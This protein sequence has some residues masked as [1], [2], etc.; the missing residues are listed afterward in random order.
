[1]FGLGLWAVITLP[2]HA[3]DPLL[4]V[5]D[6]K[7]TPQATQMLNILHE[8][9]DYGLHASDYTA[10]LESL[11]TQLTSTSADAA[12]RFDRALTNASARFV[13]DVHSG[14][15]S[16]RTAGFN[17]PA[18]K[19]LA[20]AKDIASRLAG[21]ANVGQSIETYEPR[22]LPYRL[23]KQALAR[24]RELAK[25]PAAPLPAPKGKSLNA[26]EAYEGTAALRSFLLA[27]GDLPAAAAQVPHDESTFDA[28]L[29]ESLR[30]FQSRH[31][32]QADGVLGRQTLAALNVPLSDRVRQIEL[33]M[34]RWR[35]LTALERPDIVVNIPQFRLYALPRPGRSEPLVEMP[36][37]VGRSHNRTPV[38]VGAIEE[39]IFHPYWDVPRSIAR[40]ELLPKARQDATYLERHHFEIV[41]GGSDNA[42][43]VKPSE[44]A[45]DAVETGALRLR[46]RPGPDNALGPVKFVLPN[47]Y[48]V[49]LHGTAEPQLF[50]ETVR[51]FSHGCIRVGDPAALAEYVL[52]DAAGN[53]D[54]AAV[55][56]ALCSNETQRVKL[57]RPVRVI[58][59]YATAAA[60]SSGGILF[61]KDIYGHDA[62]L[63]KLLRRNTSSSLVRSGVPDHAR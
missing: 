30:N 56:K 58:I 4:W 47:P 12:E 26:G 31:G 18:P 21:A 20:E 40:K 44:A 17:L 7:P 23:L 29:A 10:G 46:Q 43:V 55:D 57:T 62:R 51:A 39:V 15:V 27:V 38:F 32:L 34:E 16:A 24:Y 11:R 52:A 2:G 3:A 33:S 54:A 53:W 9:E 59:F 19:P 25:Q 1:M 14:R 36:V 61:S 6:G 42:T 49:R 35:W 60:T 37:I 5:R 28:S 63:E 45:Y 22:P 50:N 48:E 41:R 13:A 8:A